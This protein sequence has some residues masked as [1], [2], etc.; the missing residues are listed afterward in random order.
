MAFDDNNYKSIEII[1]RQMNVRE[2]NQI[3]VNSIT[4]DSA[5]YSLLSLIAQHLSL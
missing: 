1:G 3:G 5:F 2:T 4:I